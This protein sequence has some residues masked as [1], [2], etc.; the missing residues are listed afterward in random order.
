MITKQQ[1]RSLMHEYQRSGRIGRAAQKAG[2][3]PKTASFYLKTG[4][5]PE[6]RR[7]PRTWRTRADPL[8][9]IW[10]QARTWLED[11]PEL[12]AK[13]LFEHLLAKRP[14]DVGG[15]ALRSFYRRVA[16]WKRAYGPPK[17][18]FFPQV[19][20]A[21]K[22]MQL[23]WTH[24]EELGVTL[25]RVAF[26]HL[27]CHAVLPY[28]NWQWAV[29]CRSESILS[30]K[31]GLQASLW[32]MGGVPEELQTD[33][34]STAT[35]Q[36][37][38]GSSERVFNVEYL[39]MCEHL[40]LEPRTINRAC[41][42]E[43]GDIESAHG[44]LKRRL[45]AHLVLRGSS[46]FDDEGAYGLFLA[47]VCTGANALRHAKVTEEMATLRALP[48]SRYPEADELA[49]RVSCHSTVRVKDC[50]YSVPARLIGAI[51]R[52]LVTE[53][54]VVV[55]Y[56]QLEVVRYPRSAT[57]R[58]RIDYRHIIAS[59]V[60]KPGAFANYLYREELFPG[61]VFRQ[62][63]DRLKAAEERTADR[64]YLQLLS[65]AAQEGEDRV[66]AAL[67]QILRAGEVPLFAAVEA[68]LQAPAPAVATSVVAFTPDLHDYDG[69]LQEVGT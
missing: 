11:A 57:R 46:D 12:E 41:P 16:G 51:V 65:L 19:R 60:R 18:V 22:S 7:K 47:R 37:K 20:V 24:A 59:L 38:R 48:A 67:G 1:H 45:K 2:V 23:D 26:P 29:P 54:T 32:S 17:E 5:I 58:P 50:A 25:A 52:V 10:P 69:L 49:V 9:T 39:A 42:H 33:R 53:T 8:E 21:G 3:D 55:R 4:L 61:T 34:S 44:H 63:Y 30:L 13:T 64:H 35:H 15:Q 36:L 31:M 27:L 62:A 28:S 66:A 56:E 6:E 68:G 14:A 43:N 40:K